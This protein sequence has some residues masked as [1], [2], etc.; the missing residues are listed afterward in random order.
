MPSFLTLAPLYCNQVFIYAVFK[1]SSE[2]ALGD[3][4]GWSVS[5]HLTTWPQLVRAWWLPASRWGCLLWVSSAPW[6][7]GFCWSGSFWGQ[8]SQLHFGV[9]NEHYRHIWLHY[10]ICNIYFL[11]LLFFLW[12][13]Y[14]GHFKEHD[15]AFNC[16]GEVHTLLNIS[17]PNYARNGLYY[18]CRYGLP[19]A[20]V[21]RGQQ[22]E[23]IVSCQPETWALEKEWQSIWTASPSLPRTSGPE[24]QLS[25]ICF[26]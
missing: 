19:K 14:P 1:S 11:S 22:S 26:N 15:S 16:P 9:S 17:K 8:E 4:P 2:V 25:L 6:T 10:R 24:F 18:S 21:G 5:S 7:S 20:E 3:H 23:T 13:T 12:T